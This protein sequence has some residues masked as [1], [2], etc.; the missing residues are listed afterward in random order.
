[1]NPRSTTIPVYQVTPTDVSATYHDGNHG[2][3]GNCGRS[4]GCASTSSTGTLHVP[5]GAAASNGCCQNYGAAGGGG[6]YFGGGGVSGGCCGGGG[7]G[8]GSSWTGTLSSPSFT[9]GA[10][11][12]N[13]QVII[14]W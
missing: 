11:T 13:G 8:G 7:A 1:M 4:C 2:T 9:A 5:V 6:G 3:C 12:G 10:R 14:S